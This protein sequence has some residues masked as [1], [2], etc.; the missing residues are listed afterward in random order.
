MRVSIV[1]S[2]R[3]FYRSSEKWVLVLSVVAVLWRLTW[4]S[5]L[6]PLTSF[7][8]FLYLF[9]LFFNLEP[10]RSR[11]QSS[12]WASRGSPGSLISALRPPSSCPFAASSHPMFGLT[13]CPLTI[14]M[15]LRYFSLLITNPQ[16]LFPGTLV[17]R[18]TRLWS[19]NPI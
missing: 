15:D 17:H 5:E 12:S 16:P 7:L 14:C 18:S 3:Y 11:P 8:R 19:F 9:H 2:S 13:F 6:C 10:P 1:A 4:I